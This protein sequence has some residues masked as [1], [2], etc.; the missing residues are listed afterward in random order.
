MTD[1]PCA[2]ELLAFTLSF[3]LSSHSFIHTRALNRPP[4][5]KAGWQHAAAQ[6]FAMP[7]ANVE[8]SKQASSSYHA[9]STLPHGGHLAPSEEDP[10]GPS[11][12]TF[13]KDW[14]T[15]QQ[16]SP[17]VQAETWAVCRIAFGASTHWSM[18]CPSV[19]LCRRGI[20]SRCS[21]SP[22]PCLASTRPQM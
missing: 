11:E 18:T 13:F 1:P 7:S 12:L 21:A 8:R 4:A 14:S 6:H 10:I 22:L 20:D 3:L 9:G 17:F 16:L 2:R 19:H 5:V 15:R